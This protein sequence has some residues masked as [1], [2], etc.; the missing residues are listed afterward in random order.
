MTGKAMT[1]S[2][3]IEAVAS[4]LPRT[5]LHRVEAI[6][7]GVFES[8]AGALCRDERIEIR[9]FGIF[10]VR[11]RAPQAARNPKTGA[12]VS[13]PRRR[14]PFFAV[15]KDLRERLNKRGDGAAPV[16]S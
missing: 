15:G 16:P 4:R 7:N 11:V 2:Q 5:P 9:G 6:V 1:K 12:A 14:R 10:G 3:L 8:M 13:V